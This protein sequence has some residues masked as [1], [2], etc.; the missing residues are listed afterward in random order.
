MPGE[1][2]GNHE[3]LGSLNHA[4]HR[5]LIFKQWPFSSR[6]HLFLG[7]VFA[8]TF[9]NNGEDWGVLSLRPS[10]ANHYMGVF[11]AELLK[12]YRGAE[13]VDEKLESSSE[14]FGNLTINN[15]AGLGEALVVDGSGLEIVEKHFKKVECA[16]VIVGRRRFTLPENCDCVISTGEILTHHI[17][18]GNY[19]FRTEHYYYDLNEP[20]TGYNCLRFE[21]L[22]GEASLPKQ[23]TLD[24][25][26]P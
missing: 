17:L 24:S 4:L 10:S 19:R 22:S 23:L 3:Y 16:P 11:E 13:G 6:E 14:I 5:G 20:E 21:E 15:V 12:N 9:K 8:R 18:T 25:F 7:H 26:F 2:L 1:M